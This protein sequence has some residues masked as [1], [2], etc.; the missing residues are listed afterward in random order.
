[1]I[2]D[3]TLLVL[4]GQLLSRRGHPSG[5]LRAGNARFHR[6]EPRGASNPRGLTG[7]PPR[8]PL[9]DAGVTASSTDDGNVPLGADAPS[10]LIQGLYYSC[11][12][13]SPVL[14]QYLFPNRR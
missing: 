13:A 7:Y 6:E 8:A 9:F 3:S 1:M 5:R 11:L 4:P 2:P 12:T 10:I 14:P